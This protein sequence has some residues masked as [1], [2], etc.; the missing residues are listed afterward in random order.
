MQHIF[1]AF[2]AKDLIRS[3]IDDAFVKKASRSRGARLQSARVDALASKICQLR[4]SAAGRIGASF[5]NSDDDFWT[6]LLERF[7]DAECQDGSDDY[8]R[9]LGGYRRMGQNIDKTG[10]NVDDIEDDEEDGDEEAGPSSRAQSTR[11]R[12]IEESSSEEEEEEEDDVEDEDYGIDD[13]DDDED[14]DYQSDDRTF[15]RPP[16]ARWGSTAASKAGPFAKRRHA[17]EE[18]HVSAHTRASR[19]RDPQ[20]TH[21]DNETDAISVALRTVDKHTASKLRTHPGNVIGSRRSTVK[22]LAVMG[23][24]L[25]EDGDLAVASKV[26]QGLSKLTVTLETHERGSG[27]SDYAK[28]TMFK[29]VV[30]DCLTSAR[31]TLLSQGYKDYAKEIAEAIIVA[32]ELLA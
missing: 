18:P 11:K 8:E 5:S 2:V 30:H 16:P 27:L 19:R 12:V 15:P 7:T 13:D 31:T 26:L 24:K 3:T 21:V 1:T 20:Q 29:E 9:L 25:L 32:H 10:Y 4:H 22:K 6:E 28:S 17:C 14:E 23:I